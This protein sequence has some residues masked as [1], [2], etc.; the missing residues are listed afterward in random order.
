MLKLRSIVLFLTFIIAL[1]A[2]PVTAQ[3][4]PTG[5]WHLVSYNFADNVAYPIDKSEITLN[6]HADGKLGGKSGCNVYGGGY[7]FEDSKLKIDGI[8]STQMFCD[9]SSG[10][11]ETNYYAT[12]NGADSFSLDKGTL[13]ITNP[14]TKN[15]LKFVE[16][17]HVKQPKDSKH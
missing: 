9:E 13:T 10:Q 14:K 1:A 16:I 6:I 17:E 4:L 8:I 12:L 2:I 5:E 15:F 7:S 11:F 3:T